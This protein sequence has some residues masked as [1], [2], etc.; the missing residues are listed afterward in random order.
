MKPEVRSISHEWGG[1]SQETTELITTIKVYN[2][3]PFILP[4]KSVGCDIIIDGIKMGH[5]ETQDLH[6]EKE[7]EFPILIRTKIDNSKIPQ[8]WV[9]HIK[10]HE[11]SETEIDIAVTFDL[12]VRD[13]TFHHSLKRPL[14]TDLLSTLQKAGPAT[15]EK[16]AKLPLAGEATVLKVTLKSVSSSWGDVT[17]EHTELNLS[18]I[19]HND[20][21]YSLPLPRIAYKVK[22][23]DIALAS[24]KTEVNCMLPPNSDRTIDTTI[25]LDNSHLDECFV[26]HIRNGERSSFD[27]SA[28]LI[29]EL[30][31]KIA[32]LLGENETAIPVWETSW[33]FETDI[34]RTKKGESE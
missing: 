1:I 26:S 16:K 3:N 31:E 14:E 25:I 11:Q 24:D 10:R 15:I 7:A 8:L 29:F 12:V 30:P 13:F 20:N 4:V 17:P 9:E 27:I 34:L 19:V 23:N 28:S 33:Q 6:I 2:P 18:A 21:S 5:A 22:L 32:T